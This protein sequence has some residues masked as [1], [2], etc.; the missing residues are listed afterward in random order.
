MLTSIQVITRQVRKATLGA[1]SNPTLCW[2]GSGVRLR[3]VWT[4]G[5][6]VWAISWSWG[7]SWEQTGLGEAQGG[8]KR[9]QD[10]LLLLALGLRSC[11]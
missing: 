7:C 6:L 11:R 8:N 10:V 4:P 9:Q 2:A 1:Y 5:L 3:G